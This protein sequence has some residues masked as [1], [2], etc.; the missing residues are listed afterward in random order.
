MDYKIAIPTY[1]RYEKL[2]NK[3]LN[4]LKK[5]NIDLSKIFI[6]V[7]NEDEYNKYK[8]VIGDEYNIIIGELGITNQ[9]NFISNFFNEG[10]MI[11]SLDDDISEIIELVD[12]EFKNKNN[13]NQFFK[14]SFKN[15]KDHN[16]YI[17]GVYSIYNKGFMLKNKNIS[18]DLKFIIGSLYGFIVRK[19]NDLKLN[20]SA[21]GKEDIE[22]SILYFIKDKIVMRYNRITFKT[23]RIDE[24]GLGK[25]RFLINEKASKYLLDTYP[26]MVRPYKRKNGMCEITMKK[27]K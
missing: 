3:T 13:L 8:S 10:E 2:K 14:D 24:G 1:L 19:D 12:N 5:N 6:F 15:I 7:A 22:Q 23:K 27:I 17:W 20:I 26:D 21:E 16:C 9:R 18:Y 4:L 11:V 25:D